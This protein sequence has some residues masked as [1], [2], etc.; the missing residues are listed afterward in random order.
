[1]LAHKEQRQHAGTCVGADDGTHMIDMDMPDT[2]GFFQHLCQIVGILH[3]VAVGDEHGLIVKSL[4]QL[5]DLFGQCVNG[6]L[7]APCLGDVDQM[8]VKVI[9]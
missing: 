4:A 9:S 5:G 6:C 3:T 8:A 7:A 1:M 2:V